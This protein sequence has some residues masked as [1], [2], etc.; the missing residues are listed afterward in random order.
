M[1]IRVVDK[2]EKKESVQHA[3]A[4]Q[5]MQAHVH[6]MSQQER[7]LFYTGQESSALTC[8]SIRRVRDLQ[9]AN[10]ELQRKIATLRHECSSSEDPLK[11]M[12]DIEYCNATIARNTGEILNVFTQNEKRL[13]K[14]AELE[15]QNINLQQEITDNMSAFATV[16]EQDKKTRFA[17]EYFNAK[18]SFD[19]NIALL[20]QLKNAA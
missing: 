18:S 20:T 6:H 19:N 17:S 14:I 1:A 8:S 9:C 15:R 4:E 5:V 16:V 12:N 11:I 13:A 3:A 7:L 10:D 2:T